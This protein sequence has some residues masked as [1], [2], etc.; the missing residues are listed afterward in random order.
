MKSGVADI[1]LYSEFAITM[2]GPAVGLLFISV[3]YCGRLLCVRR[4]MAKYA[5]A[6]KT[7]A[8]TGQDATSGTDDEQ[9]AL[10]A[11]RTRDMAVNMH[12]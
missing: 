11:R 2:T 10:V 1:N 12:F 8:E 5:D 9:Y 4:S 6:N 7:D 3:G